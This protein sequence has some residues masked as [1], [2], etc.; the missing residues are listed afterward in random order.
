MGI[1][2]ARELRRNQTPAESRLWMALRRKQIEG[3]IFRRQHPIGPYV[4][5]F[6]CPAANLIVELDGASHDND[7]LHQRDTV[8]TNWLE[9]RGYSVMRFWNSELDTNLDGVV[10]T[11]RNAV[12][13]ARAPSPGLR[14]PSPSRGEGKKGG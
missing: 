13:A 7:T 8:R 10:A 6:F 3:M 12:I 11:I 14:P 2:T 1:E 5:D 4:T 9:E